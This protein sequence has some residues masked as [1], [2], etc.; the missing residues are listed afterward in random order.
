M[1]SV[2]GGHGDGSPTGDGDRGPACGRPGAGRVPRISPGLVQR[3][4]DARAVHSPA[5]AVRASLRMGCQEEEL[6]DD[7]PLPSLRRGNE[8]ADLG[9][10]GPFSPPCPPTRRRPGARRGEPAVCGGVR[11]DARRAVS[12]VGTR[13]RIDPDGRGRPDPVPG[14]DSGDHRSP[15]GHALVRAARASSVKDQVEYSFWHI[16]IRD[17]AYGQIPRAARAKKHRAMAEWIQT[18]A[19]ERVVDHVEIVAYHYRQALELTRAAGNIGEAKG[20]ELPSRRFLV[21]AG[22]RAIGLD[23]RRA[24]EHYRAALELLPRGHP[25]RGKVLAKAAE[26]AARAGRFAER[27]EAYSDAISDL[28]SLSDW[29]GA[30]DTMVKLSNLLWRRGETSSSREVLAEAIG[31]LEREQIG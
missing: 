18:I 31:V 17:V 12:N 4:P 22:D 5:G 29:R 9:V 7:H 6:D 13:G 30:G 16:L 15:A 27:S 23:V 3:R 26:M 24:S 8:P 19:G 1:A 10:I 25:E 2:L 20:L 28:R 21:M 14:V 11:C